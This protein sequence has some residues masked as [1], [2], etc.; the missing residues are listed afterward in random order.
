MYPVLSR[1]NVLTED[2][3]IA[4]HRTEKACSSNSLSLY[5]MKD[6]QNNDR[7][8]YT[9]RWFTLT[10]EHSA[11]RHFSEIYHHSHN[12]EST[13]FDEKTNSEKVGQDFRY[14]HKEQNAFSDGWISI[15]H[16]FQ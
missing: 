7:S 13:W 12:Y 3:A 9:I 10:T 4:E 1:I 16:L 14:L 8:K 5:L 11:F 15:G 6:I 2:L